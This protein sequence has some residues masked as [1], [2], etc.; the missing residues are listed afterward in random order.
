[1]QQLFLKHPNVR[2]KLGLLDKNNAKAAE[3]SKEDAPATLP[4]SKPVK[5]GHVY[6]KDL[7]PKELLAVSNF[8]TE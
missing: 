3:E 4:I 1:M 2:A 8:E 5:P 6:V 7:S